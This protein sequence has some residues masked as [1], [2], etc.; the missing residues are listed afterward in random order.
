LDFIDLKANKRTTVGK[1]PARGLRREGYFPAVLYGPDSEPVLLSVQ[2]HNL[3]LA[4][5]NSAAG[6]VLFS[7]DIQ[8]GTAEKHSAMIKEVQT[9]PVSREILHVDFMEVSQDRKIK[10]MVP[11]MTIGKSI[12]VEMGGL[13]QIIRR[14]L[15]V[16]CYPNNIPESIEIDISALEIGDSVHV[17]DIPLKE[18]IEIPH[19][20]DFTVVTILS[21]KVEE[22]EVEEE[23]GLEEGEGAETAE[24]ETEAAEE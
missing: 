24:G 1:G 8:D 20:V 3:T 2:T 4:L 22:E 18:G 19:D 10:V 5:K 23:E 12:G 7:L 15:E 17:E 13:F 21:P 14:D 11:V 9:D 6:Q 16:E